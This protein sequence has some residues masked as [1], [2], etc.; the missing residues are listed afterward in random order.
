MGFTTGD[1]LRNYSTGSMFMG[2]LLTVAYLVFLVD[3]IPFHKRVY[4]ALCLDHSLR[5]VGWNWV[6]ANIPPP[7][8]SPRWNFVRE[9]LFR[10]VR[11]FLLLDLARSYMYLDPLFSLTGAD[12][13]SITSQG[14]ALCCLNIIAWGYTPYGMVNLQYSL[15]ADVHVGLSY[16]DSQDW[17]DPFGAW[18]DAYTIRCFWG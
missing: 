8:K 18:S 7:P 2:Q 17:P 9:Q 5:G 1:K 13:R 6:V 3:Q 4:W 15:L 12:A 11:C 14:Y 10:A 16:S